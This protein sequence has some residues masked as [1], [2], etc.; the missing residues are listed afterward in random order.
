M[1]S[2][3]PST[4]NLKIED[5]KE[6]CKKIDISEAIIKVQ[7]KHYKDCANDISDLSVASDF[8][9]NFIPRLCKSSRIL[10]S[11]DEVINK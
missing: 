1:L 5:L 11:D 3:I 4:E 9:T 6:I 7:N 10:I 8:A 2:K